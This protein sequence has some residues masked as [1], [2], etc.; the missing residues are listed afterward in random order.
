MDQSEMQALGHASWV[1][2][3]AR[4]LAATPQAAMANMI[5]D[6]SAQMARNLLHPDVTEAEK[7]RLRR[8][9][10]VMWAAIID[11][12]PD[13]IARRRLA[14]ASALDASKGRKDA[15]AAVRHA[16]WTAD[17]IAVVGVSDQLIERGLG[18]WGTRR[19][20]KGHESQWSAANGLAKAYSCAADG[21]DAL[22][23]ALK[24]LGFQSRLSGPK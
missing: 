2:A 15:V 3:N 20:P 12:A 24:K 23:Y 16:L 19:P 9:V 17:P 4:L 18:S 7:E 5:S 10:L 14:I 21:P 8:I 6:M 11:G 13:G 22:R 1:R